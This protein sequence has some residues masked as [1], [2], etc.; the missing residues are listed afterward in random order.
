MSG[1]RPSGRRDSYQRTRRRYSAEELRQRAIRRDNERIQAEQL[2][3][4]RL[5][6]HIAGNTPQQNVRQPP[7]ATEPGRFEMNQETEVTIGAEENEMQ[8]NLAEDPPDEEALI[9]DDADVQTIVWD[10]PNGTVE[11]API[12]ATFDE[13]AEEGDDP[14]HDD[15]GVQI[16]P[17][18]INEAEVN[19]NRTPRRRKHLMMRLLKRVMERLRYENSSEITAFEHKWAHEHLEENG[20]WISAQAL[21]KKFV[22]KLHMEDEFVS[23]N[24]EKYY[25][26][27]T[28]VWFPDSEWGKDCMPCCVTCGKNDVPFFFLLPFPVFPPLFPFFFFFSSLPFPFLFSPFSLSFFPFFFK[29]PP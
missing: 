18:P 28:R 3:R 21:L 13:D 17:L 29:L 11:V 24:V 16:G 4:E 9:A 6:S 25:L 8:D 26:R 15:T 27:D 2:A 20:F 10:A 22:K 23:M 1:G 7:P 5:L 14:L 19:Q 12:E